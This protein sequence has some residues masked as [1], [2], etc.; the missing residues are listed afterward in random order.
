MK[1]WRGD[2]ILKYYAWQIIKYFAAEVIV[3]SL[4][5]YRRKDLQPHE[6]N[7]QRYTTDSMLIFIMEISQA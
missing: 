5:S 7:G 6:D 1:S 4:S 2:E 3:R